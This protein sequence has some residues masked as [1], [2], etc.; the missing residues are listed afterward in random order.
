MFAR[1]LKSE[2]LTYVRTYVQT[3][4]DSYFILTPSS[5]S[6]LLPIRGRLPLACVEWCSFS[7]HTAA[8][9]IRAKGAQAGGKW[10]LGSLPTY[11]HSYQ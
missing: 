3:N 5:R 2:V 7:Q 10:K 4:I 8:A 11:L 6:S 1:G 9:R